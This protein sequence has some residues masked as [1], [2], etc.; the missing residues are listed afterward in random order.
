LGRWTRRHRKRVRRHPRDRIQIPGPT[1]TS[2]VRA[3]SEHRNGCDV[4]RE[5]PQISRRPTRNRS[6]TC[7]RRPI[8]DRGDEVRHTWWTARAA[9]PRQSHYHHGS[10]REG[11]S[12]SRRP[13]SQGPMVWPRYVCPRSL[14]RRHVSDDGFR[15]TLSDVE[16]RT[17]RAPLNAAR[18]RARHV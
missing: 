16:G 14:V 17:D 5:Q 15:R 6:S 11:R 8:T 4:F 2:R 3:H 1:I 18:S 13:Q 10:M 7:G 9:M 12:E